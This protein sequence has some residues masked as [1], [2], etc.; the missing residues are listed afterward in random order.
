MQSNFLAS[1][2]L[3]SVP[4]FKSAFEGP[5]KVHQNYKRTDSMNMEEEFLLAMH[6]DP[7]GE[8]GST[9]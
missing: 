2:F 8:D 7:C 5:T 4:K 1:F 9:M 6:F 3:C